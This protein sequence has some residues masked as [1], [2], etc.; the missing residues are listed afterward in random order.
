MY[1]LYFSAF[2]L[3]FVI[4]LIIIKIYQNW[5]RKKDQNLCSGE[6]CNK[7]VKKILD[8]VID[9][10]SGE[11][12]NLDV[13]CND[14]NDGNCVIRSNGSDIPIDCSAQ[15]K[16]ANGTELCDNNSG[17]IFCDSN[18][19]L[20]GCYRQYS[21]INLTG[22]PLKTN[23]SDVTFLNSNYK[24]TMEKADKAVTNCFKIKQGKTTVFDK[25]FA[26]EQAALL[27]LS[28]VDCAGYTISNSSAGDK[29][30]SSY[31]T[32][33]LCFFSKPLRDEPIKSKWRIQK[34]KQG[35]NSYLK[36]IWKNEVESSLGTS[37]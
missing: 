7:K 11:N 9:C 15:Y 28:N 37:I 30:I 27:C 8:G 14:D 32:D 23:L 17:Q 2:S 3:A 13:V 16:T 29:S 18:G 24:N 26:E 34:P 5:K 4:I 22:K 6:Q 25:I 33:S 21:N 19:L 31:D 1:L 12:C 36:R 20:K 35:V 10:E